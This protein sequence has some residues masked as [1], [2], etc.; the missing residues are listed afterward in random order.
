[1]IIPTFWHIIGWSFG[2]CSTIGFLAIVKTE[3]KNKEEFE[4]SYKGIYFIT[5]VLGWAIAFGIK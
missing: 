1:M 2:V 4:Q 3:I 5:A